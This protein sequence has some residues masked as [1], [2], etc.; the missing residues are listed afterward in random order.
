LY[1]DKSQFLILVIT[2]IG[3]AGVV[4]ILTQSSDTTLDSVSEPI[5]LAMNPII[6]ADVP[7]PDVI[8]AGDT[9]YMVSTSMHMMPGSPI[10]RSTDLVN[11]EIIGY[12]YDR[13]EENDT[14]RLHDGTNA[15]GKGSWANSLKYHKGKFYVLTASLDTGKTYLFST[16]DPS[17]A[18]E[19]TEFEEY[20][21]DPALLF[22]EDDKAYIIYGVENFS[23]KEL[24]ADYKDINPSGLDKVIL[25]SGKEGMEGAHAYK[26]NG[27]YYITFIWWEKGQIRRQYV[28]RSDQIDGP[29]EGK[30]VLSDTMGYKQNGVAQGGLVDTPDGKW[31]AML[32]Q[33]HNAVG[34]IPVLVPVQWEDDWPVYGDEKGKIPLRIAKAR[35]SDVTMALTKSDEFYQGDIAKVESV[36]DVTESSASL[37]DPGLGKE[38]V[39]NGEFNVLLMDWWGKDA[40]QVAVIPDASA[41]D[42]QIA[43]ISK[44]S[45]TY[46][47]IGQNF[48]G[49]L[50]PGE[51]YKAKFKIKYTEG[52]ETKEFILTAKKV[53]EG[54][55]SYDNLVLGVAKRGEW[56]EVTGTFTIDNNPEMLQ[57]FFETPWTEEPDPVNDTMDFYLDDVSIKANPLTSIEKAEFVP[58]GSELGMHWQWNHNPDNTNWSLIERKGFLRLTT[59]EVV[60]DLQQARNTLTQRSQGPQSSG[61]ISIDTSSM[62][63]GD[64]AGLAA[65]QQEYGFIGVTRENGAL[66][67]VMV[68][69]GVENARMELKQEQVYLKVDF[70]FVTDK[71]KFFYSL[72]GSEWTLFGNELLMRYTIPHFM[73][74]RFALFN[75]ATKTTG[76]HVDFDFFRF[77]NEAMGSATPTQLAAYLKEDV[78]ELSHETERIYNIRLLMDEFPKGNDGQY[79]RAVIDI[80]EMFEVVD[81]IPNPSNLK[82]AHIE[83][84]PSSK[85]LELQVEN[86]SGSAISFVNEDSSKEVAAIQIKIKGELTVKM[87]DEIKVEKLEIVHADKQAQSYDVSGAVSKMNFT[88]PASA[89]GKL[90]PNGNPVVSH[91][92]G[93]DP[94]AL[95]F[96][97]RVYLYNTNDVL[98]YDGAGNV[99]DNSYGSINK[100]SVISS[101]DLMNWTDHGVINA[102][103]PKGAAKWATQSWAPAVAH[104][105]INGEDK[106]FIYFANNAS[107]IGV[108]TSDNPIGPWED[109]IGKPL[110]SRS[111]PGA[112]EVT[113]LFDP[114]VLLDDD[115]KA[116]IYFGGGIPEGREEMPNTARVMELGDD[117]IS[118]VGEA[119]NI[120]APFMFENAGINK[121]NGIYYYT[122]CSNFYS[123]T[124]PEGSPPAGQIAY[125]TSN[126]PMGPWTYQDTILK[127]PGHFFGVG[128]NNHHVIFQFHDAWYIAY[129]AQTLSK[130]MG[131]PKGYRS[132]HLNQVFFSEDGTIQEIAADLKGVKQVKHLNPFARI[133]AV[134]MAWN[135]GIQAEPLVSEAGEPVTPVNL[136]VTNIENGDWTAVSRVD[137]GKG[138]SAFKASISSASEGGIIEL[139]LDK[140]NGQLIGEL[141]V[142]STNGWNNWNELTTDV[143][144]AEGVHDLYFVFKGRPNQELFQINYWEFI[145]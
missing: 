46:A 106:F 87:N 25:S 21:H 121:V 105:V 69:K 17:G 9:Y 83:Y 4:L 126:N 107:G 100:L 108:L 61:W 43:H 81:V 59:G 70:D 133:E 58:N 8:R 135:V 65:F 42:N 125:M 113:W 60:S 141:D 116:Y 13:L 140:P 139:R 79:I 6:Y 5:E 26:I 40:A 14:Y 143:T 88:P 102:A 47:G 30:L 77:S 41:P 142:S 12:P 54:K 119:V 110:I 31:Y 64:Y 19:R 27:K 96:E 56:T 114:A 138:A 16:E 82:A 23:I 134:T 55:T 130:A 85:R 50:V 38:L 95:V 36:A 124:R 123:G 35:K 71:A 115:G 89:I 76:G 84:Q 62:H 72:N 118:V 22:D 122:Y 3:I 39:K 86:T 128:G 112:E 51:R 34:R 63:D 53:A 1:L 29:Y 68:D 2:I 144:G 109:P 104:K 20:W 132:T 37:S 117:M 24:T 90:P 74:Y 98:E 129:H 75:Y 101:D 80:P 67:I 10:M 28:Y 78:V 93:A 127:N 103:G 131:V 45:A 120:P 15:Y 32:F 48:N 99:K 137:F 7:D 49:K 136:A 52:P 33:D 111:T 145:E 97:D 92:F 57:L 18:W 73:G 66:Y 44:R 94:Y 91:K 11:W